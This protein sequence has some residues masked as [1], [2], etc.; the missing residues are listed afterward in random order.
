MGG[1]CGVGIAIEGAAAALKAT[2]D[3]EIHL[4]GRD[5]VI[6]PALRH[7]PRDLQSRLIFEHCDD[8]ITMEEH[9]GTAARNKKNSSMY[10]A[11][12]SVSEGKTKAVLSAGHSGA[13]MVCSL[14][15]LK[16]IPGVERPAIA[17]RL[18]T[19]KGFCVVLDMGANVDCKAVHLAQFALMGEAYARAVD[20]VGR[21]TV[22]LLSNGEEEHKGT[23]MVREAL[24]MS[25]RLPINFLGYVE[26]ND[27]FAHKADV[28]VCDGFVGNVVLKTSEGLGSAIMNL[29]VGEV[30]GHPVRTLGALL[31]RGAIRVLKK[32]MDPAEYG[33]APLLGVQGNVFI[34]HGK[35]NARAM[36]C[37]LYRA[38]DAAKADLSG[39]I[40]KSIA[41][42]LK[43]FETQPTK[44]EVR[45]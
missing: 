23:E 12:Q 16:R 2:P 19:A 24:E 43:I 1:E 41:Q 34:S 25:R 4:F 17:V 7:L 21:P 27:I 40:S 33:A 32:K 35:S 45:S 44:I 28:V 18:P 26:G 22:G 31:M 6:Q 39:M 36:E 29:M 20:H 10:R 38:H 3:L 13:V 42:S 30:K 5:Q 14:F 8:E 15:I 9:A 37:A 11:I